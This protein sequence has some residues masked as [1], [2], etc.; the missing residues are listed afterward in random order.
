MA[1]G[2]RAIAVSLA[3]MS[4][5]TMSSGPIVWAS[6]EAWARSTGSRATTSASHGPDAIARSARSPTC[7]MKS[8]ALEPAGVG[9]MVTS[10]RR[11][12]GASASTMS[13]AARSATAMV[14]CPLPNV[15]ASQS[16]AAAVTY[17]C[18]E[19]SI[20][21]A[22]LDHDRRSPAR[23]MSPVNS[24]P[25]AGVAIDPRSCAR[26]ATSLRDIALSWA[27]SAAHSALEG[28]TAASDCGTS[29]AAT[30]APDKVV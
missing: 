24:T 28:V 18:V 29:L 26:V 17:G 5:S 4:R 15:R 27:S 3:L 14:A 8:D 30:V 9:S 12:S 20:A 11:A 19:P 2:S 25:G 13:R 23:P 16:A 7:A 10:G 1:A 22:Q 21:S 6:V